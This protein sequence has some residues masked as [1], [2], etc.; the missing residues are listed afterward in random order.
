MK[1]EL[2]CK[3]ICKGELNE[4]VG[5]LTSELNEGELTVR[6]AHGVSQTKV[7]RHPVYD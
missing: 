5:I 4:G 3:S 7:S 6:T 2:L 1:R